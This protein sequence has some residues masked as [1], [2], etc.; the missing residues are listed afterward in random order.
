MLTDSV[1]MLFDRWNDPAVAGATGAPSFPA[2]TVNAGVEIHGDEQREKD[3][4]KE[5]AKRA[6]DEDLLRTGHLQCRQ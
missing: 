2:H 6:W 5:T 4:I 3:R 1:F